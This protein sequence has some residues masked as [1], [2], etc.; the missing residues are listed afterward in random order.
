MTLT[1]SAATQYVL[2]LDN[3]LSEKRRATHVRAQ[4]S[5]YPVVWHPGC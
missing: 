2:M 5:S 4:T 1:P 3:D